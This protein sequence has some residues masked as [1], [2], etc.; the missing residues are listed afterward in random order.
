MSLW[1][2]AED[3]GRQ[4]SFATQQMQ[5]FGALAVN[6]A[7]KLCNHQNSAIRPL[8]VGRYRAVHGLAAI[9][10]AVLWVGRGLNQ[11]RRSLHPPR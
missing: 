9:A 3:A 4:E 6:V 8:R 7:T 11:R 5:K 1:D 10:S 2:T